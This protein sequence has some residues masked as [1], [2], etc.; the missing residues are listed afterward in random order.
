MALKTPS[1]MSEEDAIA[2]SRQQQEQLRA[3][4]P[5]ENELVKL[6]IGEGAY[7]YGVQQGNTINWLD[8]GQ[9]M[10]PL[11]GG[12]R[13]ER[14]WQGR[15]I[16]SWITGGTAGILGQ[17][18]SPSAREINVADYNSLNFSEKNIASSQF[19][20]MA[21]AGQAIGAPITPISPVVPDKL[22]PESSISG[23]QSV[24]GAGWQ[25]SPAFTPE[26]QAQGIFG[27]VR[28]AGTNEVY[29]IGPGGR[30]ETAESFLQRFGTAEQEGI[31]G[32]IS[33]EQALKLGVTD[34]GQTPVAPPG[35]ITPE[36]METTEQID[37]TGTGETTNEYTADTTNAGINKNVET[38]NASKS[39]REKELET[40]VGDITTE[41]KSLLEEADEGRGAAQ[42]TAEEK[43]EVKAKQQATDDAYAELEAKEAEI[44]TLTATYQL[45]NQVIEGKPITMGS[46]QGQQ[47]QEYKMYLA[48]KNLLTSQASSLQ[49]KAF[50]LE[51]KLNRAQ[52][53]ADRSVDL[54]YADIQQRFNNQVALYDIAKGELTEEQNIR[55]AS[56]EQYTNQQQTILDYQIDEEK[57][58]NKEKLD[59][60]GKYLLTN[61]GLG[62]TL[63]EINAAAQ[64]T[65]IYR[66]QTRLA[67][68]GG[69]GGTEPEPDITEPTIEPSL[70]AAQV[71]DI[72]YLPDPPQWFRQ[73]WEKKLGWRIP[74][75]YPTRIQEEWD[76][77][78]T[79]QGGGED[80]LNQLINKYING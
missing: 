29:T 34:T 23:I 53:A 6:S 67:G 3:N 12:P 52:D 27:A 48:Q 46:I 30:K 63:Q 47:A 57:A 51:G 55:L 78:R 25:P 70:T 20:E 11:T 2:L 65:A 45:K 10:P 40:E 58:L 15:T 21:K 7:K 76:R 62:N 13:G 17:L 60:I 38:Y 18:G 77:L 41:M 44:G 56:L 9:F 50:A 49:A 16:G 19:L 5:K 74:Q 42:L 68:G 4:M 26:L 80:E 69:G 59:L 31:V 33:K 35:A 71:R 43:E 75:P 72:K 36:D 64:G 1:G 61:V 28:I 24:F 37:L 79:E 66:Q 8:T 32:E 54:K 73:K 14:D 39:D 22:T